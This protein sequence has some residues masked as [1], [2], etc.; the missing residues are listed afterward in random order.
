MRERR[1]FDWAII[2]DDLG[3]RLPERPEVGRQRLLS[4]YAV[5]ELDYLRESRTPGVSPSLPG[6]PGAG[7]GAAVGA[8][9]QPRAGVLA[10]RAG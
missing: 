7:R 8:G 10:D 6:V 4:E 1:I 5:T 2:E 3:M 9:S